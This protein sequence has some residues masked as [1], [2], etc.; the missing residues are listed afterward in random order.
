M[1]RRGKKMNME[2]ELKLW[3]GMVYNN[4]GMGIAPMYLQQFMQ[5]CEQNNLTTEAGYNAFKNQEENE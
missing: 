3:I 5:F 2:E 1:V 4:R